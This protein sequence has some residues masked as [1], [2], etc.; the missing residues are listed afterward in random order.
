MYRVVKL[1]YKSTPVGYR[2]IDLNQNS[3]SFDVE[4]NAVKAIGLD[5][6]G[7]SKRMCLQDYNGLLLSS[8]ERRTGV[9]SQDISDNPRKV[10][11]VFSTNA[12]LEG[13]LVLKCIN[14]GPYFRNHLS[15]LLVG[16]TV[17]SVEHSIESEY[18][19][20]YMIFQ[21]QGGLEVIDSALHDDTMLKGLSTRIKSGHSV[22]R[23]SLDMPTFFSLVFYWHVPVF[24][25]KEGLN[26]ESSDP[27]VH[28]ANRVHLLFNTDTPLNGRLSTHVNCQVRVSML[29][30]SSV[31]RLNKVF[32]YGG[33]AF[34]DTDLST[35]LSSSKLKM[36]K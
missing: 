11:D 6:S 9:L 3:T 15:L 16:V 24:V 29:L 2:A 34:L 33:N 20:V 21:D 7:V 1:E 25:S 19:D 17:N 32:R 18:Y 5:L 27:L 10:L 36:S 8:S 4:N 12:L 26:F 23:V 30:S 13:K 28:G 31:M 14:G 22:T 35:I